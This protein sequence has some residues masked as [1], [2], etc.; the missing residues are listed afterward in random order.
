METQLRELIKQH[1]FE[2]AKIP[3][4]IEYATKEYLARRNLYGK[5]YIF[6]FRW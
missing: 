6:V 5:T 2:K 1:N 4:I 3:K